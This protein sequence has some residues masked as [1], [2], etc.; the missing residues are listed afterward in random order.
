MLHFVQ[1]DNFKTIK[2]EFI[3][4]LLNPDFFPEHAAAVF[5]YE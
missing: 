4:R 3:I 1:H 2:V 5:F